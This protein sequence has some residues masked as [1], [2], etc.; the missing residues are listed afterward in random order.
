MS[1][2][3]FEDQPTDEPPH[4]LSSFERSRKD[5]KDRF[6]DR[7]FWIGALVGAG[8]I[9]LGLAVVAYVAI[10]TFSNRISSLFPVTETATKPRMQS[11]Q[12]PEASAL[13]KLNWSGRGA[14]TT[15]KFAVSS[16]EWMVCWETEVNSQLGVGI[17]QV[18]VYSESG[19]FVALAANTMYSDCNC[20]AV[21]GSGT[22]YLE[23]N[24]TQPWNLWVMR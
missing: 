10:E 2:H 1:P 13:V 16:N 20:S 14:K 12:T 7:R 4:Q 15:Q 17:F 3:S 22:F 24:A 8:V 18:Y 23:V 19:N 11:A 6:F 21:Y 5:P 9:F